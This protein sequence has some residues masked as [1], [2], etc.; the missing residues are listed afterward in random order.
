[1]TNLG[2]Q[3]YLNGRSF[4][5]LAQGYSDQGPKDMQATIS[6]EPDAV[7]GEP[8]PSDIFH[9]EKLRTQAYLAQPS[10]EPEL[11]EREAEEL[12][13][14]MGRV[15]AVVVHDKRLVTAKCN[16]GNKSERV[17]ASAHPE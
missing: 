14:G 2:R 16:L 17:R 7:T 10:N 13:K 11:S 15:A 8:A 1:M 12:V 6:F 5:S 3:A 4:E 9:D